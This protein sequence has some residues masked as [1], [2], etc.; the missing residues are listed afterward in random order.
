MRSH[1]GSYPLVVKSVT[2]VAGD[3]FEI[4]KYEVQGSARLLVDKDVDGV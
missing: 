4:G 2:R 3:G 1:Y